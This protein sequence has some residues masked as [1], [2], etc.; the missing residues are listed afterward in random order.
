MF[1]LQTDLLPQPIDHLMQGDR[2]E[3]QGR[4]EVI[5]GRH[6]ATLGH[7]H[8]GVAVQ[9]G[10]EPV[11]SQL[12]LQQILAAQ[13]RVIA[14]AALVPLTNAVARRGGGNEIEPIEA[15]VGGLAGEHLHEV[16]VLQLRGQ[17]T[18][19]VIDAGAM[20]MVTHLGMDPVGEIH[21]RGSLAQPHHIALGREHKHLFIE[22]VFLDRRQIVVVVV[23]SALLLPI[24]QL[25]QPVEALGIAAGARR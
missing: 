11:A 15:G 7:A 10:I 1:R 22:Q 13:D 5:G 16:A 4:Q 18:E 9:Q 3:P 21:R 12:P 8:H 17:G 6:I 25:A 19:P 2:A 14:M 20:A 24:H 23:V